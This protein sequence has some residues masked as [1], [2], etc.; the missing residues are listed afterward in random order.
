MNHSL[1]GLIMKRCISYFFFSNELSSWSHYSYINIYLTNFRPQCVGGNS[2]INCSK[3][4]CNIPSP[5]VILAN[6]LGFGET[7]SRNVSSSNLDKQGGWQPAE[8]HRLY[9]DNPLPALLRRCFTQFLSEE[10]ER[11]WKWCMVRW[12]GCSW[13]CLSSGCRGI[14]TIETAASRHRSS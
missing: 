12:L 2:S 8:V 3:S 6:K 14:I 1:W 11:Q 5:I 4:V 13:P 7:R 9:K 10:T